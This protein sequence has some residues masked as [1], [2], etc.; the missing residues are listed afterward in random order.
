MQDSEP[1]LQGTSWDLG[2]FGRGE[3]KLMVG[4]SAQQGLWALEP[5]WGV[6]GGGAGVLVGAG[7]GGMFFQHLMVIICLKAKSVHTCKRALAVLPLVSSKE[8]ESD[9]VV[10]LL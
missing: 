4:G 9:E 10:P 8:T 5:G 6:V 3:G 1:V 2:G 7:L